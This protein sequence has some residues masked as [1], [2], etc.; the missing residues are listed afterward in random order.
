MS[1]ANKKAKISDAAVERDVSLLLQDAVANASAQS[2][3]GAAGSAV[4]P[5]A[6]PPVPASSS[7]SSSSSSP[8]CSQSAA[9]RAAELVEIKR[10]LDFLH[11]EQT[12]LALASSATPVA[13]TPSLASPEAFLD[14]FKNMEASR[15]KSAAEA[16]ALQATAR[17][18]DLKGYEALSKK[19][20]KKDAKIKHN[21]KQTA[22]LLGTGEAMS[23]LAEGVL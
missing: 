23:V 17:K 13:P 3:F 21:L 2:P 6:A 16:S 5:P 19:L 20:S 8:P 11:A 7:S 22:I 9:A 1:T 18:E 12:R 4:L 15:V 10:K 14:F